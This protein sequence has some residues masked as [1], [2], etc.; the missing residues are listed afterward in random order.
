M[1]ASATG[2]GV[3]LPKAEQAECRWPPRTLAP[4]PLCP[5]ARVEDTTAVTWS[6]STMRARPRAES[7]GGTA[8]RCGP[9]C[10]GAWCWPSPPPHQLGSPA[11]RAPTPQRAA[12]SPT[13]LGRPAL[14][15]AA[16]RRPPHRRS[17]PRP[18][19]RD[20]LHTQQPNSAAWGC[21]V[22]IRSRQGR[23]R[24]VAAARSLEVQA[25]GAR[26]ER[27]RGAAHGEWEGEWM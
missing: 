19:V 12:W 24:S 8:S 27:E 3:L 7:A 14:A 1:S 5:P 18:R 9:A 16:A 20:A 15:T 11:G 6:A 2:I 25:R 13:A 23:W 4:L 17:C 21:G 10:G 26:E 22:E